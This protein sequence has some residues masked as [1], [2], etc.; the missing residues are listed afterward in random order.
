MNSFDFK[1][2]GQSAISTP[3]S[4]RKKI[5]L[6]DGPYL[7]SGVTYKNPFLKSSGVGTLFM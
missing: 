2:S 1:I 7:L 3:G 6:F 5:V 4:C